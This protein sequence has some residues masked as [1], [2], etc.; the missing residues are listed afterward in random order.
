MANQVLSFDLSELEREFNFFKDIT[1]HLSDSLENLAAEAYERAVQIANEKLT[2]RRADYLGALKF[3]KDKANDVY[4][5]ELNQS[6]MWIEEGI[7]LHNMKQT[8]LKGKDSVIIP[9]NHNKNIPSMMSSKQQQTYGEIKSFLRKQKV[10]LTKPIKDTSGAPILSSP[11]NVKPAASFN[12]IPSKT[13][14]K[15]SGESVLNRMQIYQHETKDKQGNSKISKTMITFRTLSKNSK[16]SE[17]NVP[18]Q[19]GVL[20]LDRV[21]DFILQN[22]QE[23]LMKSLPDLILSGGA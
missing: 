12:K 3:Y 8:H 19:D 13:V 22:Y 16:D 10:S 15:K 6:A 21:Y 1:K 20:I 7:H 5:I 2:S 4:V 18:A 11:G 17:W 9:F 23:I 14:S